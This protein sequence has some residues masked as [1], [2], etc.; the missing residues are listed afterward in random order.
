MDKEVAV[1]LN[2]ILQLPDLQVLGF[3]NLLYLLKGE[4]DIQA[5]RLRHLEVEHLEDPILSK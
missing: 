4:T 1:D 2:P 5:C 3:K